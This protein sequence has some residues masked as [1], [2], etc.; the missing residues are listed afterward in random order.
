[1][2]TKLVSQLFEYFKANFE[3][4]ILNSAELFE[5]QRNILEYLVT[6]GRELENKVFEEQG[7]GYE[8]A[9]VEKDGERLSLERFLSVTFASGMRSAEVPGEEV[10]NAVPEMEII[11]DGMDVQNVFRAV[12]TGYNLAVKY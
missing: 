2:D 3:F 8:G 7:K 11:G 10:A 9:K 6:L 4:D 12:H 5:T 1:M